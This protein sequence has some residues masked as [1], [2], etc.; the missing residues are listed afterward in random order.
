MKSE[1]K[2]IQERKLKK[3]LGIIPRKIMKIRLSKNKKFR[4]HI[5][6]LENIDNNTL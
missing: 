1:K 5:F 4:L 3:N 6:F 2:T